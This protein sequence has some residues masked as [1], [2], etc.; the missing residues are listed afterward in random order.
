LASG[1]GWV[2]ASE[3]VLASGLV[4]ASVSELMWAP[5]SGL[6]SASGLELMWAP[7]SELVSALP[8]GL[9]LALVLEAAG[10]WAMVT[11]LGPAS[12]WELVLGRASG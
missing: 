6:E 4:S 10:A 5:G 8:L 1:P 12:P 11:R 3:S 2:S 7:G 9:A